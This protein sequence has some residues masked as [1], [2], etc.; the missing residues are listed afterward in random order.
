MQNPQY[1][2]FIIT[3][4]S[5]LFV[6]S[7]S[8]FTN[9]SEKKSSKNNSPEEEIDPGRIIIDHVVNH[10][11]WHICTIKDKHISVPLPVILYSKERGWFTFLSNKFNHG[12]DTY[13][14]FKIAHTE[15]NK[16]KI[17]ELDNNGQVKKEKPLDLSFTQVVAGATFAALLMIIIFISI[18]RSYK[19][20]PNKPPKGLQSLLEPLIIFVRD[21]IAR[22][23]IGEDKYEKF[24]PFL[25][26]IFF[27]IFLNN[28]LGLIPIFPAGA[29]V[30]GNITVTMSL[31]LFTFLVL[32]IS[33]NKHYWTEIVNPPAIPWWLKIPIPL[34]P[35]IEFMGIII[36]PFVLMIR[37]FANI[38]AG[39]I[40]SL[41]FLSLIFVFGNISPALGYGVSVV[42][43]LFMI[44]LTL[45]ELLVAFIQAYVF[46]ILSAIYFGMAVETP[47]H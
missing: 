37:L 2:I 5:L 20:Q 46:T 10:Y 6:F 34:I 29:N 47:E 40:I 16:G 45:L 39:H 13:K 15:P 3:L 17:V 18:A 27:F 19:K 22:S 36:K 24:T 12:H 4:L 44:F 14:N 23:N 26:S 35:I 33:G 25:L 31:A 30:T 7:S 32:T 21:D 42:S 1:K 38:S 11:S 41:G 8:S 43:V 28:L 9:A